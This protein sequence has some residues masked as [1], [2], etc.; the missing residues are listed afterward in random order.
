MRILI[1]EGPGR[2]PAAYTRALAGVIR[3]AGQEAFIHPWSPAGRRERARGA[4]DLVSRTRPDLVHVIADDPGLAD[5]FVGRDLP[6]V[7]STAGVPSEADWIVLPSLA[8]LHRWAGT[9]A[10]AERRIGVLP[11]ALDVEEVGAPG[12]FVRAVAEDA[13][14]SRWVDELVRALPTIPFRREGEVREARLLLSVSSTPSAWPGGVAE[15][16]VAGRPVIADWG[17][18]A[19]EL[20]IEGIT[21]FLSAP[22]DVASLRAHVEYLWTDPAE[23]GRL[24][25]RGRVQAR[26]MLSPDDHGR[27]LL[28]GYLRA[29]AS[30]LAV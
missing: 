6:V 2:H 15:A 11:Y 22:G 9:R 17:G 5:A 12:S 13:T 20:V 4:A 14:S 19:T 25:A 8:G 10:A 30:R 1:A 18:A 27:S 29:G 23:A 21:G 3:R 24:G 28:R 26:E 7:H 16:M